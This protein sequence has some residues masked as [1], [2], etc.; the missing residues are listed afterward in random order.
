MQDLLTSTPRFA[1]IICKTDVGLG[2]TV[3]M[4]IPRII[5]STPIKPVSVKKV[6]QVQKIQPLEKLK[7][8]QYI[9]KKI[10]FN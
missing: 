4:S 5:D 3:E 10:A 6:P 7:K 8:T 1:N 9:Y 2:I